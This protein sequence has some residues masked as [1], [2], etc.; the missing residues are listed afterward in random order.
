MS[1]CSWENEPG[2]AWSVVAGAEAVG[3]EHTRDGL[4]WRGRGRNLNH[5]SCLGCAKP[6]PR[7]SVL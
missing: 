6:V 4:D 1:A 2:K 3:V 5:A 7:L